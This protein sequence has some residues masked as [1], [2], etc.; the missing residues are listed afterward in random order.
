[1]SHQFTEIVYT[2]G[3]FDLCIID[4][5]SVPESQIFIGKAILAVRFHVCGNRVAL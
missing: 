4:Y 2:L 5:G 1:M 3:I